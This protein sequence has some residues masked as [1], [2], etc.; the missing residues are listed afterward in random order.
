[1]KNNCKL[2]SIL[3]AF[4]IIISSFAVLTSATLLAKSNENALILAAT[5]YVKSA[6]NAATHEGLLS[7]VKAVDD[8]VTLK[9]E[10]FYIKHSVDGCVDDDTE[11][12]YPLKIEGSDG[13][14]AAVFY[15]GSIP[16]TFSCA[17]AHTVETI[18]INEV[19]I[20]GVSKGFSYDRTKKDVVGYK[21]TADK[22]VFPKGYKGTLSVIEDDS[23]FPN[24]DN[25]KVIMFKN[26]DRA[27]N[28]RADALNGFDGDSN[29][30]N[31]EQWKFKSLAAV[32]IFGGEEF[33]GTG[34]TGI[35]YKSN[36]VVRFLPALKY[37]R[38]PESLEAGD[39]IGNWNFSYLPSLSNVNVPYSSGNIMWGAFWYT[40]ARELTYNNREIE[41][42]YSEKYGIPNGTVNQIDCN[43]EPTFLQG[44][45]YVT[46]SVNEQLEN[47]TDEKDVLKQPA[48]AACGWKKLSGSSL[49]SPA[50]DYFKTFKAA[51]ESD[52][53]ASGN[54]LLKSYKLT[55]GE[56]IGYMNLSKKD[57]KVEET[58][59]SVVKAACEYVD[60]NKNLCTYEGLLE[61]ISNVDNSVIFEKDNFY[62]K[63]TVDGCTDTDETSGYPLNISGSDGAVTAVFNI[64]GE[65][66]TFARA[67]ARKDEIIKINKVAVVGKDSD[68][69][70]DDNGNVTGY[71]GNADKI[72]F[73]AGYGGTL[74][75]IEDASRFP[76]RDD[77]KVIIFANGDKSVPLE[78]DVLNGLTENSNDS[79]SSWAWQSLRAVEIYKDKNYFWS[80][81]S[82]KTNILA[83][84]S[85][86]RNLPN[87]KYLRLPAVLDNA[88]VI[89]SYNVYCLPKL[90][91]VNVPAKA[92]VYKNA[93]YNTAL[94][95]IE[96]GLPGYVTGVDNWGNA[97]HNDD[98]YGPEGG[99]RNVLLN[100]ALDENIKDITFVQ[101]VAYVAANINKC[102]N[103]GAELSSIPSIALSGVEGWSDST[104]QYFNAMSAAYSG[105]WTENDISDTAP[106]E[107]SH[108][109]KTATMSAE[110]IKTIID[111][112]VD[113]EL[114]PAFN[115]NIT[116]YTVKV[117]YSVTSL[118]FDYTLG[119]GATVKSIENNSD[120]K[121]GEENTVKLTVTTSKGTD[122][123]YTVKVIRDKEYTAEDVKA[124]L[125]AA[126]KSFEGRNT[127]SQSAY[128][129]ALKNSIVTTGYSV[130]I[131]DFYLQKSIMGAE[132]NFGIITPGYSG[133]IA[134]DV[135]VSGSGT[136]QNIVLS[137]TVVPELKKY[138]FDKSEVST[139]DDFMLS[140]DGKSLE[141]YTGDA[142]K[143][144]IPEGVENIE[145]GWFDGNV[146]NAKVIIFPQSFVSA[147]GTG[148]CAKLRHLEVC[149]FGDNLRDLPSSSFENCYM[150]QIVRLPEPLETIGAAAFRSTSM[151]EEI[152]IPANVQSILNKAFWLSGLRR[153]T[154]PSS[155]K[156]LGADSFSYPCNGPSDNDYLY[157]EYKDIEDYKIVGDFYNSKVI[158]NLR[159]KVFSSD[160]SYINNFASNS[161]G[162][163]GHVVTV[164]APKEYQGTFDP[165]GSNSS[166]NFNMN[167]SFAEVCANARVYMDNIV[168][169][170]KSTED[171]ILEMAKKSFY[172]LSDY[173]VSWAK[174]FKVSGN[175]ASGTLV[176]ANGDE[177]FEIDFN[178]N[179]YKATEITHYAFNYETNDTNKH[180]YTTETRTKTEYT[181]RYI[182]ADNSTDNNGDANQAVQPTKRRLIRKRIVY[183]FY[184]QTWFIATVSAAGAL[185]IAGAVVLVV[186]KKKKR[187]VKKGL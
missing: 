171:D 170:N 4:V 49:V 97:A 92:Y 40:G 11:S 80:T 136:S 108:A 129:Q 3:C 120:F 1:M 83:N 175:T 100:S 16:V 146:S 51:L 124:V 36:P 63:H 134:A 176:I 86:I 57:S 71:L 68:F 25:V 109:E 180:E 38:L 147:D 28:L 154:I 61:A 89:A 162:L 66:Y 143:I 13:A 141:Y 164:Y 155:V 174:A 32:D 60:A 81:N 53:T 6:K 126:A 72:V 148:L 18:H 177:E 74:K 140:S 115:P 101:A 185:L 75:K 160:I 161:T 44:L 47:G 35:F 94:R 34:K 103:E 15:K 70:Y 9:E 152:Y 163:L 24:R 8:S 96:F 65:D 91:N 105:K 157:N 125:K 84:E 107:I 144:I 156:E 179:M 23:K 42:K 50:D 138:T 183:P 20:V 142:K 77:V 56:N 88:D 131:N 37:L 169:T 168:I 130:K 87:L 10:D 178:R 106:I 22:I 187:V 48:A 45:A 173:T 79:F 14:V 114:T 182:D 104:K 95:E 64:Y 122:V 54:Y 19:A 145:M 110:K 167:M 21:G 58:E 123:T 133:S 33:Y 111:L 7:A 132:D 5:A 76:G 82:G 186:I 67:F 149:V 165:T 78:K 118:S 121:V 62:I 116:E 137:S 59:K 12:G 29:E 30:M 150:L 158:D 166:F 98:G 151:L 117:P 52:W 85:I 39:N 112:S 73:P 184:M 113:N 139:V 135:T 46:A 69:L 17:F 93:F 90:E 27:E 153:V 159:I 181:K 128:E 172:S 31:P 41:F 127:T 102:I 43:S 2:I 55:D 99:T 119:D 26:S